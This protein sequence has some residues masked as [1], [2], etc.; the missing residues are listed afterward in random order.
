MVDHH[1]YQLL[2]KSTNP[3]GPIITKEARDAHDPYP[4]SVS[5]NTAFLKEGIALHLPAEVYAYPLQA[6]TYNWSKSPHHS[7]PFSRWPPFRL[8]TAT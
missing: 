1:T 6:V 5:N 7:S 2:N 3:F 8:T 4:E